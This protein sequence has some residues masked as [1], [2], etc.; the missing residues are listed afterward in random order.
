MQVGAPGQGVGSRPQGDNM[1]Q[2]KHLNAPEPGVQSDISDQ[3]AVL[4]D[5]LAA[6]PVGLL[7]TQSQWPILVKLNSSPEPETGKRVTWL[8]AQASGETGF[9]MEDDGWSSKVVM[10]EMEQS[11]MGKQ[12][13]L[14]ISQT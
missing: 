13:V 8:N 11:I 9:M 3:S 14:N 6:H 7:H 5:L 2:Q 4:I 10:R 12:V 1:I